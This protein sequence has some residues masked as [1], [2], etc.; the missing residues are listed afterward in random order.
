MAETRQRDTPAELALR[1]RLHRLGLRYRL[2]VRL[3]GLASRARPDVVF[4]SEKVVVYVDGCF[5]HSCPEHATV[6]KSN[7]EWWI[8]KLKANRRRDSRHT[9]ELKACGWEVLRF[10][11][12]E[13]PAVAALIVQQTVL[14]RRRLPD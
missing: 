11:E 1:S 13:D 2:N 10:W 6:P 8:D 7:A 5:W 12:H 14:S 9:A 3:K 4:P